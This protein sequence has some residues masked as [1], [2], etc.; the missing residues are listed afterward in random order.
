M[1]RILAIAIA[2]LLSAAQASADPRWQLPTRSERQAA[3]LASWGSA[4]TLVSIDTMHAFRSQEPRRALLKEGERLGA[5]YAA[6]FLAKALVHRARPCAPLCGSDNPN[7]SFFSGHTAVAFQA[8][9][10]ARLTLT[11]PLAGSTGALRV[12]AGK[13]WPSDVLAGAV[14]GAAA[15]RWLR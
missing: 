1:S 9:G 15:S 7:F 10:G 5:T 8:I 3:N 2:V 11:V 6:V 13:H 14:V 4:L 12:A